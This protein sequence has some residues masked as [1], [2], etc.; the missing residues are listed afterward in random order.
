MGSIKTVFTKNLLNVHFDTGATPP[1]Q[2]SSNKITQLSFVTIEYIIYPA[3][4]QLSTHRRYYL[5]VHFM[6]SALY[7]FYDTQH[8]L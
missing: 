4:F 6:S 8:V 7:D 1:R 3:N 5:L 2:L